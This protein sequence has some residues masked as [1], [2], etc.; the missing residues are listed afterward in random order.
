MLISAIYDNDEHEIPSLYIPEIS[1]EELELRTE[2]IRPIRYNRN[3]DAK[4]IIDTSTY[5]LHNFKETSYF[6][7]NYG[8]FGPVIFE[9]TLQV[10]EDFICAHRLIGSGVIFGPTICEVLAQLPEQS[11]KEAD[12]FEIIDYPKSIDDVHRYKNAFDNGFHVSVV[13]T[14]KKIANDSANCNYC[15]ELPFDTHCEV[16]GRCYMNEERR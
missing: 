16:F 4:H 10:I 12:F 1:D 2:I 7:K 13:R 8:S 3:T 9:S 6:F 14:Y 11:L 15:K 5:T